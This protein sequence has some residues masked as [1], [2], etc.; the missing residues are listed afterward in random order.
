MKNYSNGKTNT[1]IGNT[2]QVMS[3]NDKLVKLLMKTSI[4]SP[5]EA[6]ELRRIRALTR[7]AWNYHKDFINNTYTKHYEKNI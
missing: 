5:E 6:T 3:V 7:K 4:L 1:S 2:H